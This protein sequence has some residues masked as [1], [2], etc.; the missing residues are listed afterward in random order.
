MSTYP[1]VVLLEI[2]GENE[3]L[4]Y[5]GKKCRNYLIQVE[6]EQA[7]FYR[8]QLKALKKGEEILFEFDEKNETIQSFQFEE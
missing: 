8:E 1:Y 4:V 7:D 5:Y 6:R 2:I 3:L